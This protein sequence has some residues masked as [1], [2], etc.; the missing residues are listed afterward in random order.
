VQNSGCNQ[1][2]TGGIDFESKTL[3]AC[4]KHKRK[5]IQD[6]YLRIDRAVSPRT[7]ESMIFMY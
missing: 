5:I 4:F 1:S 6:I 7:G 3:E 2:I